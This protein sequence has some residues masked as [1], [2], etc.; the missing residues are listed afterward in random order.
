MMVNKLGICFLFCLLLSCSDDNSEISM[1]EN[2]EPL[3]ET[4]TLN[5]EEYLNFYKGESVLKRKKTIGQIEYSISYVPKE[6][7]ALREVGNTNNTKELNEAITH[8]EEMEYLDFKIRANDYNDEILKLNLTGSKQY[9]DRVTYCSFGIQK[10]VKIILNQS[11]TI[12]CGLIHYERAFNLIPE[13]RFVVAFPKWKKEKLQ[14]QDIT[15]LFEDNLFNNG[16]IKLSFDNQNIINA[17]K[18]QFL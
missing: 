1:E 8:Y 7:M 16:T 2:Q 17:P 18:L 3:T 11:D 14:S 5:K 12:N 9:N 13:A 4:K 6:L 10:D 15:F